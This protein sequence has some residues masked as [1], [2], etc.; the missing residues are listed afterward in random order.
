[1]GIFAPGWTFEASR[2]FGVNISSPNGN[3]NCNQH[4]M[5]RNDIFWK[6]LWKYLYSSGP[7]ELP[8]HSTFCIGSGKQIYQDGLLNTKVTTWWNLS[9][10]SLQPSVPSSYFERY[11]LES[12]SGGC[13]L[14]ILPTVDDIP[15][16]L[17][18]TDF[19]C[20]QDLIIS[21]AVKAFITDVYFDLYINVTDPSRQTVC[22][23]ICDDEANISSDSK[24]KIHF[25][26]LKEKDDLQVIEIVISERRETFLPTFASLNGWQIR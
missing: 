23:I 13:C 22:H 11:F 14:K 16:R 12:F 2:E 19:H 21:F 4:F 26:P 1:M 18:V 6:R 7:T 20:D 8:F 3:D 10:Q 25:R 9:H 15:K 17:F 24:G 5:E